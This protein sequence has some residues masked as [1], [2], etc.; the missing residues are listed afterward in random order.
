MRAAPR[1]FQTQFL[2]YTYFDLPA[3][4]ESALTTPAPPEGSSSVTPRTVGAPT[5]GLPPGA[6][7]VVRRRILASPYARMYGL[8]RRLAAGQPTAYDVVRR[9]EGYLQ[10]GFTYDE[11]PPLRPL[12]LDAFLFHDKIGYCQQFSGAMALLLRMDGIPARVAAGFAPGVPDPT[13]K[14]YVVRDLDAHSWVEVWFDGIGWVPFDPT[15]TVAPAS[16]QATGNRLPSAAT[17]GHESGKDAGGQKRLRPADVAGGLGHRGGSAV[18]VVVLAALGLPLI[19]LA[20]LWG[21]AAVRARRLRRAGGDPDLGE[22]RFALERL[23]H[24]VGG[25]VT[26]LELERRLGLTA[27]AGAARYV[28]GLRERRFASTPAAGRVRLDR[29]ALRRALTE[30]RGPIVR[31]RALLVLPPRRRGD[32]AAGRS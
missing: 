31:L 10:R 20:A 13:T 29:R 15:P 19:G 11:R 21:V 9:V 27:G 25:G 1:R 24:R 32:P 17:G 26:L 7:P 6:D 5:P 22:L 12:P 16:A 3:A 23:G 4:G 14:E 8:A 18:W 2:S 28:A 30:G